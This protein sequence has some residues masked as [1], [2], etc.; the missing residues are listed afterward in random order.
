VDINGLNEYYN[1]ARSQQEKEVP[2]ETQQ[3]SEESAGKMVF[4]GFI[5]QEV[6]EAAKKLNYEF[7]GVDKPK[8]K[9][10][11][12]GLRYDNFVVPLVKAVQEL[13]AKNDDLQKQIDDLR[14]MISLR[15]QD[16]TSAQSSKI[17][18]VNSSLEQNVPNPF[19]DYTV[20]NYTYRKV[21]YQHKLSSLINQERC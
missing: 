2:G 18:S 17:A 15:N 19:S 20:I 21:L 13:S 4:N 9:D 7:S 11:I 6:D 3:H 10:G 8:T 5:A 12:Y 16:L 1:K 14:A